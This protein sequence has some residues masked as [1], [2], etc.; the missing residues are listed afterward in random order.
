MSIALEL[1]TVITKLGAFGT[2]LPYELSL[3]FGKELE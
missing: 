2:Y 3:R 1:F